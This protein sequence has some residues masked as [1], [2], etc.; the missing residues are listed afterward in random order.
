MVMDCLVLQPKMAVAASLLLVLVDRE[1]VWL[2]K[3][4]AYC[5]G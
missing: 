3:L 1:V 5:L 2:I 4:Y